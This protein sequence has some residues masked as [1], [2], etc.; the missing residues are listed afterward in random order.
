[1]WVRVRRAGDMPHGTQIY[2]TDS[3]TEFSINIDAAII[4]DEGA[5]LLEKVLNISI[6]HWHRAPNRITRPHLRLHTG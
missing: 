2:I 5:Q 1:M 4:T 3:T 6:A